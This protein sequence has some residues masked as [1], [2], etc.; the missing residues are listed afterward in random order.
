MAW[1]SFEAGIELH[2]CDRLNFRE[3]NARH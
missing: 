1:K 2:D 3:S